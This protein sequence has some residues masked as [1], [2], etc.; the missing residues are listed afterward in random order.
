M[1]EI[2]VQPHITGALPLFRTTLIVVLFVPVYTPVAGTSNDAVT[3][4]NVLEALLIIFSESV[5][6][7]SL[8]Q[9][10]QACTAS[11]YA[12]PTHPLETE[13]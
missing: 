8:F 10:I 12:V 13:S 7:P 1:T 6:T 11:P 3:G 9:S 2:S 4:L 5:N